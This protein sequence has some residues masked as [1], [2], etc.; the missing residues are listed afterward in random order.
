MGLC[1]KSLGVLFLLFI[2]IV[3]LF[4]YEYSTAVVPA[5]LLEICRLIFFGESQETPY[6]ELNGCLHKGMNELSE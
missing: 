2:F 1:V 5:Y 4:Y 3:I 6:W